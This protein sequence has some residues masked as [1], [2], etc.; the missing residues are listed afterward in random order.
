MFFRK[1]EWSKTYPTTCQYCG[2]SV[3]FY[4]N[5]NGSKVFFDALGDPWPLHDCRGTPYDDDFPKRPAHNFD[6]S[7]YEYIAYCIEDLTDKLKSSGMPDGYFAGHEYKLRNE[8]PANQNK[9]VFVAKKGKETR[10]AF[11]K[12]DKIHNFGIIRHITSNVDL[13]KSFKIDDNMINNAM[14]PKEWQN[15]K[16]T[17]I[18]IETNDIFGKYYKSYTGFI[19]SKKV[20][21][22]MLNKLV[23]FTGE[24][25]SICF[26]ELEWKF[27]DIKIV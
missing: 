9:P 6:D 21:K 12:L 14:L 19:E 2:E 17:K 3:F 26:S 13:F 20:S 16:L 27:N 23:E 10:K 11:P 15:S 18:T 24:G 8:Y 5:S 25:K 4:T 22:N 7:D 1:P